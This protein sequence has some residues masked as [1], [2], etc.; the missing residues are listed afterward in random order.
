MIK[1]MTG[2]GKRQL[3]LT[4]KT[5]VVEVRALNSKQADIS[6]KAPNL[7][8]EK[9]LDVRSMVLERLERGKIDIT[10][11][12]EYNA[13]EGR[14]FINTSLA[15]KYYEELR[16]LASEFEEDDITEY[17]PL[18]IRIPDVLKPEKEELDV[19]EWEQ[20]LK[21][22]N[23]TLDDV[24]KYRSDE[25]SIIQLDI[26][27]LVIHIETL[28]EEAE[29][30]ETGRIEKIRERLDSQLQNIMERVQ[31]DKNRFEQ[32]LIYYLDKLDINEEK[33]RLKNH[34]NYF[35]ETIKQPG[36]NGKKLGFIAQEMGREINTLGAKANEVNIQKLVVQ[37]KDALEKIKE[38][39]ANVL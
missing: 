3:D 18:L 26:M 32:E 11:S 29:Q 2:Y 27:T 10:L 37:M 30:Y 13:D 12:L 20:I 7:L 31:V 6:V 38:Q 1:S 24:D 16:S 28:L 15:R 9:E 33:V 8:K 23:E 39:L 34:C 35:I 4:G 5:Y 21:I 25:G 17:L 36:T 22:V 19:S 14:A